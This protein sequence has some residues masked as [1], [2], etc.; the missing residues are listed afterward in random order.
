M[1]V[2]EANQGGEMVETVIK[3]I[4]EAKDT[5]VELVHASRGKQT[6]AQPVAAKAEKGLIHH[7]GSFPKLEDELCLWRPGDASPNR[8]DA[9]VW[10]FSKLFGIGD[11]V[12]TGIIDFI[13]S[14]KS[15]VYERRKAADE[16][17]KYVPPPQ[18]MAR[19]VDL[20]WAARKRLAEERVKN[21]GG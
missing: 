11:V 6:R 16:G 1:I 10:G 20:Y 9:M 12:T 2:A 5:P 3:S 21:N 14:Q 19:P 4:P 8:L 7:I 15:A 17:K 13:A 18:P